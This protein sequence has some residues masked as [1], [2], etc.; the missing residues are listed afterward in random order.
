M[1]EGKREDFFGGNNQKNI[2]LFKN[3]G[4]WSI[5]F[6]HCD[7]PNKNLKFSF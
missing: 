5:F 2:L 1:K 6:V 4:T 3:D 7:D